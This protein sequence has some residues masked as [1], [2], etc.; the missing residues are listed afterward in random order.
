[1]T[2]QY[3]TVEQIIIAFKKGGVPGFNHLFIMYVYWV[4]CVYAYVYNVN[5]V[6]VFVSN[7]NCVYV[8]VMWMC[9]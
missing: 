4:Y 2:T 1:M 7:I 5:C 6:Y 8:Y 9:M 3:S